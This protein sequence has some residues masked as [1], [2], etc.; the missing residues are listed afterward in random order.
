MTSQDALTP[1]P[2][3]TL[4]RGAVRGATALRGGRSWRPTPFFVCGG[5]FWLVMTLAYWRVPMCC[6]FGQHA[7]VVERL[8]ASLLHPRH[9][10][11]DL[12]GAG[13][14]YYSPYALAQG[15]FARATGLAGW[16]VVKLAGP[17]NLLVLLSGLNR[18]V[19]TLTSRPWAPVL[20]LLAMVLLWGTRTAWWS[21]YLGLLSMTGNLG[22]P[23]TF[24]IGLTFWAWAGAAKLRTGGPW[25]GYG[26]LGV[27]M[28]VI[29]LIHP[30][31]SVA[32]LIGLGATAIPP[33][34]T[35]NRARSHNRATLSPLTGWPTALL[36]TAAV[37]SIWPYYDVLSLVGDSSV[38]HIHRQL[39]TEMPARFWLALIGLPALWLRFRRDRRDPL[40][41]MFAL[42]V[43]VIAYGWV[44]GHYTYGRIL[45]LTL[46]PLQFSLA[47]ALAA[48]RPWAWPRRT[49]GL[50][51][52]TGAALGFLTVQAG[53]VVP[54]GFDQPPMWPTYVWAAQHIPPGDVVLT[55][56]YRPTRSLPGYGPNLLAPAWPD[57]AL[58]ERERERRLTAVRAYLSPGSTRSERTAVARRYGVR[59][60]LLDK[61]QRLPAEAVM[62]AWSPRTGE[63]LARVDGGSPRESR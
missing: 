40:A 10:M 3:A 59:W 6:D 5:L 60:L 51:A 37:T 48:P 32:A 45:G 16:E 58:D 50:C 24:A 1:R 61:S 41:V 14:P 47:I 35:R 29:L 23:S 15:V 39:Y 22:Y 63:V 2:A 13:S 25:W 31:T 9:P 7:A 12:P 46:V 18:F 57:P 54:R 8:R 11:A 34:G 20:A 33:P 19:R 4:T 56:G 38:D 55:D 27:L 42:D 62:V 52:A 26:G 44:T 49:L 53:A 30:I 17:L 36:A 28:G 21:G 43:L